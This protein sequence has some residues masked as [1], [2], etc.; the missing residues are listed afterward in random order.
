MPKNLKIAVL[1]NAEPL[2]ESYDIGKDGMA[3]QK[4]LVSDLLASEAKAIAEAK[5]MQAAKVTVIA[6]GCKNLDEILRKALALGADEAIQIGQKN[7]AKKPDV[8]IIALALKE[9]IAGYDLLVTA[10][11]GNSLCG[12]E[13]SAACALALGCNCFNGVMSYQITE[14]ALSLKRKLEDGRRQEV[15]DELPA[16]IGVLPEKEYCAYYSLA[17]KLAAAEKEICRFNI[18]YSLLAK[19]IKGL[20]LQTEYWQKDQL[21]PQTKLV[22]R[23]DSC[24]SGTGRL[25]AMINGETEIKHGVRV[26]GSAEECA[27]QIVRYLLDS[28]LIEEI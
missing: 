1:L 17:G 6:C 25:D 22:W 21:R 23:P 28:G 11:T 16:V 13:L 10:D 24:L 15:W 8:R 27:D 7:W 4:R 20:N 5:A 2:L 14:N 18:S 12:S 19:Q 9:V 3:I 26:E